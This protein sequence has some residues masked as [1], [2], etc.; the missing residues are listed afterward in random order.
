[1]AVCL[2]DKNNVVLVTLMHANQHTSSSYTC[3]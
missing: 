2:Q 3:N 1:M